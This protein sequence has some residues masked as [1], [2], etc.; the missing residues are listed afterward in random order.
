MHVDNAKWT[1]MIA[2]TKKGI[3]R[4]NKS[5]ATHQLPD[6]FRFSTENTGRHEIIVAAHN[7]GLGPEDVNA[8]AREITTG[9]VRSTKAVQRKGRV[10]GFSVK[11]DPKAWKTLA[12]K[13]A[14]I[15]IKKVKLLDF[16]VILGSKVTKVEQ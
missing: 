10:V 4:W 1:D 14:D 5:A 7:R 9:E 8:I 12:N 13:S 2:E 15:I 6:K 3:E 11:P 16:F